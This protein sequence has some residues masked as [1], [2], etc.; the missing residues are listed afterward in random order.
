[1][2][3]FY[4]RFEER[5][6]LCEKDEKL[7]IKQILIAGEYGMGKRSLVKEVYND[8]KNFFINNIASGEYF[9]SILIELVNKGLHDYL[10][11]QTDCNYKD[12]YYKQFEDRILQSSRLADFL[13]SNIFFNSKKELSIET[14][15]VKF[16]LNFLDYKVIVFDN[17]QECEN[18]DYGRVLN[19][20]HILSESGK[21]KPITI[22][23]LLSETSGKKF[24][25]LNIQCDKTIL[26]SG[27]ESKYIEVIVKDF[28]DNPTLECKE[29]ADYL[30][31]KY[32][33][34]PGAIINLLKLRFNTQFKSKFSK[35]DIIF[36][37]SAPQKINL[38]PIENRIML[39][40]SILPSSISMKRMKQF[41]MKD[42]DFP[43]IDNEETI[44]EKFHELERRD[45]LKI[46]DENLK[47]DKTL[48]IL[49]KS[50]FIN[51]YTA[52]HAIYT[53]QKN[54]NNLL[55]SR[56][57][58]DCLYFVLSGKII[59]YTDIMKKNLFKYTVDTAISMAKNE[60]W[61]ESVAYFSRIINF[62]DMFTENIFTI[63]FKSI[64]YNADFEKTKDYFINVDDDEFKTF[65]Y[66]YWKGNLLYMLNDN[67][68]VETLDK[69][70][71]LAN[72]KGERLKAQVV[73]E[74]AMSELP[75]FCI[76]TLTYYKNLLNEY[77]NSDFPELSLLYRNSL[78]VGGKGTIDLCEKG[79]EIAQKYNQRAEFIKLNHNQHFEL[80]RL[81]KYDGCFEAF[82][83][84]AQFFQRINSRVYESAYGYNNLA[85]LCL[86]N[87]MYEEAR[88][89]A[90]SALI[91]ADTPY[92]QIATQVNYNL[93]ASF[94]EN[95]KDLSEQNKRVKK[96]ENTFLNYKINDCRMFRKAYFSITISYINKNQ[97]TNA[98]EYLKKSQ[99]YLQTGKHIN[100]FC[101]LCQKLKLNT[102]VNLE[103]II[104]QDDSYYNF[105][106]NPQYE[107]WLLAYGHL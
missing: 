35:N 77:D 55:N 106:S 76:D 7:H 89:Y 45:F 73:R 68:S 88:L 8:E 74:E 3:V 69:A 97:L 83:E 32:S 85:L 4:N 78:V 79:K 1:M 105:Y 15:L 47:V 48:K 75:S 94:C 101:N 10:M 27:L 18:E 80:F 100:R 99:P 64:Y 42:K 37:I 72:S 36:K 56:E 57:K 14:L 65:E 102:D 25:S 103:E 63:M 30:Y 70:I 28:F 40:L 31:Q 29:I 21:K 51:D 104:G 86:V 33:G 17:F 5:R 82:E 16:I 60:M 81:G 84:S 11:T 26:L 58:S 46:C 96:I 38:D 41:I 98:R 6:I 93:I 50:I 95:E 2:N 91:Y 52:A 24:D 54:F 67:L 59:N 66:W 19:M 39:F 23:Y 43:N 62:K 13:L 92:S 9:R 44:N 61:E 107:L 71:N 49:L 90:Y 20:V 87:G 53:L 34:N 22:I 12:L